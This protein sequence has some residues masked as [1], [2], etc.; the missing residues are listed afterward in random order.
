MN[1]LKYTHRIK[2]NR[3]EESAIQLSILKYLKMIGATVGK[4]R[5]MGVKRHG[6]FCFDPYTFLGFPDLV[7][8]YKRKLFFI[9]AKSPKGTQ[10]EHQRNFQKLCVDANISY[11][12]AK[13]LEDVQKAI[14]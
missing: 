11:I 13:S 9:E 5:T 6:R 10:T 7:C 4:T 3:S 2:K 12:L 8:F 1:Y 14:L